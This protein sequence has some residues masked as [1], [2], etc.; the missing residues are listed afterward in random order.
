MRVNACA[1]TAPAVQINACKCG[2]VSNC[3]LLLGKGGVQTLTTKGH[4]TPPVGANLCV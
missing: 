1:F 4:R 3:L 2:I